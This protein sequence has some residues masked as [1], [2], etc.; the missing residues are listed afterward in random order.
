MI[1]EAA[2]RKRGRRRSDDGLPVTSFA[3]LTDHLTWTL[4]IVASS[5]GTERF[6][7]AHP[8]RNVAFELL[9]TALPR[10]SSGQLHQI[11]E[12]PSTPGLPHTQDLKLRVSLVA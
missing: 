5:Q 6:L 12:S 9:D 10:V 4:N 11:A 1:S 7:R 8:L 2:K 3:D